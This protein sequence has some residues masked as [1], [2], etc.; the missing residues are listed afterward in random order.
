MILGIKAKVKHHFHEVIRIK[1]SPHSIVFGFA[2]GTLIAIL[3]TPGLSIILGLVVISIF[4]NISKIALFGA[5]LF[6]NPI[7]SAPL[8]ILS[9]KIGGLLFGNLPVVE[10]EVSILDNA[11]NF[12]R[13][14]LVGN[15]ILAVSIS[16][17]SYFLIRIA[18]IFYGMNK[19]IFKPKTK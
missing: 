4:K 11:Y 15:F 8:Y 17:A 18:I 19:R 16:I 2:I 9:Y 14:Y 3:P 6:W 1:K 5:L 13:R 12:T 10:Y 7:V